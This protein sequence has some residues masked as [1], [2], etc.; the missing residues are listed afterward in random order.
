MLKEYFDMTL[1][2]DASPITSHVWIMFCQIT[3]Y[4]PAKNALEKLKQ[5]FAGKY[6]RLGNLGEYCAIFGEKSRLCP[7]INRKIVVHSPTDKHELGMFIQ[8]PDKIVLQELP[9]EFRAED[10]VL[11]FFLIS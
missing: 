10:K 3:Q 1:S 8:E 6:F 2:A 7:L 11:T 9:A 4:L 5:K